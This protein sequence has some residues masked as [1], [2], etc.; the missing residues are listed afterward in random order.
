[1]SEH[2]LLG[3]MHPGQCYTLPAAERQWELTVTDPTDSEPVARSARFVA[4]MKVDGRMA[5]VCAGLNF[6]EMEL[7]AVQA[8]ATVLKYARSEGVREEDLLRLIGRMAAAAYDC[9][10]GGGAA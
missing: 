7:A 5:C 2:T 8:A 6:A 10:L 3:R 9:S 1:M 4:A